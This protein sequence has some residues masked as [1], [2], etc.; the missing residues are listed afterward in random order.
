MK[1]S[2]NHYAVFQTSSVN[3]RTVDMMVVN[4]L[5]LR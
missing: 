1:L 5:E 4:T 3:D 2:D